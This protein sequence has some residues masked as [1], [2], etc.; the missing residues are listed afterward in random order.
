[1]LKWER[2]WF[3]KHMFHLPSGQYSSGFLK[4]DIK[5]S[6][7]FLEMLSL[8]YPAVLMYYPI[9]LFLQ[10][11][12]LFVWR[13][14]LQYFIVIIEKYNI[15]IGK[16]KKKSKQKQ[17]GEKLLKLHWWSVGIL[18]IS[19]ACGKCDVHVFGWKC[20]SIYLRMFFRK[21]DWGF[22]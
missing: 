15:K 3:Y 7:L 17:M 20:V 16:S 11:I 8:A 9:V 5:S 21:G 22:S 18:N 1:M 12:S 13:F 6:W 2:R 19:F 10:L 14:I 4:T